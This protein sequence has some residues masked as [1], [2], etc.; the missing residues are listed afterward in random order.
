MSHAI[1][2]LKAHDWVI[3]KS[4]AEILATLDTDGMLDGLP[5]MPEMLELCGRTADTVRFIS[6]C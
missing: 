6:E 2:N 1:I 4:P 3:V 5:F